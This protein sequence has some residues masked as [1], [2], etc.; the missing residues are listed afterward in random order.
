MK[1]I[2]PGSIYVCDIYVAILV[3]SSRAKFNESFPH[4]ASYKTVS[5]EFFWDPEA[6][7]LRTVYVDN[8]LHING[9]YN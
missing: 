2:Q 1:T 3:C 6:T 9:I 7:R 4:E 8:I 5:F